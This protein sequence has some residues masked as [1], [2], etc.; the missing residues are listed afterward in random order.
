MAN[1]APSWPDLICERIPVLPVIYAVVS[2]RNSASWMNVGTRAAAVLNSQTFGTAPPSFDVSSSPHIGEPSVARD[3][4]KPCDAIQLVSLT[5]K[6]CPD[7]T[8]SGVCQSI[9]QTIAFV[10]RNHRDCVA[11]NR[12]SRR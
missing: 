5:Q 2:S 8:K 7:S 11:G 1:R 12:S 3:A 4:P 10:V 6:S 9:V